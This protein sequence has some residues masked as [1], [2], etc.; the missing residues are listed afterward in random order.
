MCAECIC[1]NKNRNRNRNRNEEM[2]NVRVM[3]EIKFLQQSEE[4]FVHIP[5]EKNM[6]EFQVMFFGPPD[7]V[8]EHGVFMFDVVLPSN[9][10]FDVPK[11]NFSTGQMIR[12]RIHP[13]L[14]EGGKVCISL[15]N[16]WGKNEWS[17]LL[18]IEKV[19]LAIRALLDHNPIT[20]EPGFETTTLERGKN[21]AINSRYLSLLSIK[22]SL[23]SPAFPSTFREVVEKYVTD[24]EAAIQECIRELHPYNMT[25]L[26]TFHHPANLIVNTSIL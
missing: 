23:R 26:Q 20:H 3:K 21:Y 4:L 8:F 12:A 13:N 14:Y 18:T 11:V 10:P 6:N 17:P 9:Y 1:K 24:H 22:T 15:L 7:S 5:E 16:T 19:M 2:S 25:H